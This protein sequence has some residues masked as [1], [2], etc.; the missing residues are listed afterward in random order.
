MNHPRARKTYPDPQPGESDRATANSPGEAS[1]NDVATEKARA[2]GSFFSTSTQRILLAAVLFTSFAIGYYALYFVTNPTARLILGM[3]ALISV[4]WTSS[5]VGLIDRMASALDER[6]RLR[7]YPQL[8]SRVV[9][10]LDEIKRM[11]WLVVDMDRGFRDKDTGRA[12]ME[13]IRQRLVELVEGL[14]E[15]AG[16]EGAAREA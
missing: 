13:G 7:R 1:S 16:V 9:L 14:P 10:M 6:R 3:F 4:M 8:R 11:H 5:Y 15:V 12:E 2:P